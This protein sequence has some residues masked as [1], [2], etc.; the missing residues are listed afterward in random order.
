MMFA[1]PD[2]SVWI[3][4]VIIFFTVRAGVRTIGICVNGK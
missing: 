1:A 3:Y 2:V 4:A